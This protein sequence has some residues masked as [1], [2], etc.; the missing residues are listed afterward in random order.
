M[1]DKGRGEYLLAEILDGQ[2]N[3]ECWSIDEPV[4]SDQLKMGG[5]RIGL[6]DVTAEIGGVMFVR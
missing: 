6:Q 2:M 3:E 4:G 5:L 1:I